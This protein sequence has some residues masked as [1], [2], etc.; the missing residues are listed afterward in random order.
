M[1]WLAA[2]YE[3]DATA[4]DLL[5]QALQ[6]RHR[7]VVETAALELAQK[8]DVAAFDTLVT[9]LKTTRDAAQR[10]LIEALQTLGDPRAAAAFLDRLEQ[11][12]E[13]SAPADV[14]LSAA[15]NCRRTE[16]VD[17]L[18]ALSE[19]WEGAL[20]QAFVVS[21]HDQP[22]EDAE[23][24]KPDRRWLEKQ[25]PR[26]DAVLARVLSHAVQKKALR[27]V[28]QFLPAARWAL[29][30]EVNPVL[31]VLA[32]HADTEIRQKA[33]EALGWRLRKRQGPAEPL[34]KALKH[35]DSVTQFLAAE[36]LARAGREEGLNVLLAAVDL[37]P[38]LPLR[39]R[40]V[41]ALG[42]LGDPRALDLLLKI[43]NDP[44]HILREQAV[45]ALG[46]LGRSQK[47]EEILG[48]LTELA[49]G[50][51]PLAGGALRGLRWFDHP[52][53]WQL[54]RKRDCGWLPASAH[55]DRIARLPR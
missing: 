43:A 33:V 32:V 12:T 38:T 5:R 34:V 42:E 49:R 14:L 28:K 44:E 7:R 20:K 39:Q 21:G 25:F 4:R 46:H 26:H 17:R 6:S 52:E 2:E 55:R 30:P 22:I 41:A 10:R 16:I 13:G 27:Q 23:D 47:A 37:Q 54:I 31:A 1:A 3:R 48:L 24:D 29:G 8:K 50:E 9:L 18:L 36:G 35:A 45:E 40:A 15:G 19:K 11:D 51:G 53:G